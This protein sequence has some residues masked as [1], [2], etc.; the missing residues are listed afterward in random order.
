M[1]LVAITDSNKDSMGQKN[2]IL[3]QKLFVL[4]TQLIT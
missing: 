2:D 1:L 3:E 4:T